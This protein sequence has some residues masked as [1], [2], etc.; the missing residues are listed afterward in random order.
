MIPKSTFLILAIVLALALVGSAIAGNQTS[1]LE[2]E[3]EI[4][5][6]RSSYFLSLQNLLLGEHQHRLCQSFVLPSSSPEWAI[7]LVRKD[8]LAGEVQVIYRRMKVNLRQEMLNI[9]KQK[10][11]YRTHSSRSTQTEAL[12]QVLN[13]FEEPFDLTTTSISV[14][15]A[16]LLNQVWN[17]MLSRVPLPNPEEIV[18]RLDRGSYYV[19]HNQK[20]VQFLTSRWFLG[21]DSYA[22]KFVEL[23]EELRNYATADE[24]KRPQIK[25][26]I[27]NKAIS[28]LEARNRRDL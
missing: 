25:K 2:L 28:L 5:S 4:F 13:K 18:I 8:A 11:N 15:T 22:D 10:M 6:E 17:E 7:Y 16:T 26:T 14:S 12:N 27:E 1:T 20:S 19:S 21:K 23:A 3:S 9:L 24:K